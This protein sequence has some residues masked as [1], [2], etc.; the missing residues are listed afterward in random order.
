MTAV[1]RTRPPGRDEP[2]R[3]RFPD[4][5]RRTLACG[6]ELYF[7]PTPGHP[8][9]AAQVLLPGSADRNPPGAPGLASFVA[10]LL[11]DGTESRSS[12]EIASEVEALGGG[13]ASGAD[14]NCSS[15]AL[16]LLA[17][18]AKAGLELLCDVA[19]HPRFDAG[20]IDRLRRDRLGELARRLDSAAPLALAALSRTV[21]GP[22]SP[23]HRTLL[24]TAES[25]EGLDR[26][27]CTE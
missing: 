12:T 18:D 11:E 5:E 21:Y 16:S 7:L 24:G 1:D 23:Y 19:T 6:A 4:F 13:L 10:D 15:V 27:H 26:P 9:L 25:I 22:S 3:V 14:W 17:Q 20:E 8:L 2:V